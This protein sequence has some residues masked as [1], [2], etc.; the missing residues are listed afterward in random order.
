MV[1]RF[2]VHTISLTG[3]AT[4]SHLDVPEANSM[5]ML[6]A[7]G[8][9]VRRRADPPR[10]GAGGAGAGCWSPRS[11]AGRRIKSDTM[12]NIP[13]PRVREGLLVE[14]GGGNAPPGAR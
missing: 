11:G 6:V 1:S 14:V 10:A 2:G 8:C 3:I 13:P 7:T 9:R 5:N 4:P 12:S